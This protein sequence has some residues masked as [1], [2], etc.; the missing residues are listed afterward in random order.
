MLGGCNR[1]PESAPVEATPA[2]AVAVDDYTALHHDSH[3]YANIEDFVTRHLVLDLKLDFDR[4]VIDGV[5]ELQLERLKPDARELVLDTRA[6]DIESVETSAG[7]ESWQATTFA[8]AAADPLLGSA[9]NIQ[10]PAAADRVRIAYRTSPE[11]SGLQW[12]PAEKTADGKLP[13]LFTQSQAIHARSWVPL[14]DT[15]AVRTSFEAHVTTPRG[16]LALMG[17]ENEPDPD[18]DGDYAFSM[19]QPIP[20]YLLALAAGDLRFRATGKQTGVY[21]EPSVIDAAAAEF[22]DTQTMLERAEAIYGPYRWGRY[23]LLILP[24]SFPY[25]GME[26]P[27]LTFAT[28]TVI[29]GDK[30]LVSLVAHELAHSWSGNLVTNATWRD[31]WLNEGFTTY[32]TNRIMEAVYGEERANMERVLSA[33]DLLQVIDSLEPGQG[34]LAADVR[35]KDPDESVGPI[36]YDRG[37]LFLYNLEQAFGRERF[38]L[39]LKSWFEE[40]AFSS[41]NTEAFVAF[42]DERLLSKYPGIFSLDLAKAWIYEP[43]LP[44]SAVLP[45]SQVFA[46]LD[47]Q[48]AA[49]LAGEL[50][51]EDLHAQDWNVLYWQYFIDPLPAD[52]G[53]QRLA[54]LDAVYALT[55]SHNRIL[56]RSWLPVAI[57]AD[58]A[59]AYPVVEQHLKTVGR[60]YLLT[61]VYQALMETES[62]SAFARGVYAQARPGYHPIAQ[63]AM[64]RIVTPAAAG[65]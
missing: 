11:A 47:R 24:P 39:F 62:G 48:R 54:E 7:G 25:G 37:S 64:D 35:G 28:P 59:P 43:A 56:L 21:A 6:L 29:A 38:D 12:L 44:E 27:R 20:S 5:A 52:V 9:L 58:Y 1:Q 61:P 33:Q 34:M 22:S 41:Q 14:Q 45:Q 23:D 4:H 65:Q 63:S 53:A 18:I 2:A 26:N 46:E 57:R 42:L 8:L 13:F 3:S 36:A 40:H 32:F 49:W 10:M 51:A 55:A 50:S 15:P 19:P 30:S 60:M 31:F 16:M 17:A